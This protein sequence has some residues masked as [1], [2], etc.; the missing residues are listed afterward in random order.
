MDYLGKVGDACHYIDAVLTKLKSAKSRLLALAVPAW[1]LK[2][3]LAS[4]IANLPPSAQ[5]CAPPNPDA[6]FGLARSFIYSPE[7]ACAFDI[8][9]EKALQAI[10]DPAVDAEMDAPTSTPVAFGDATPMAHTA[11]SDDEDLPPEKLDFEGASGVIDH[12]EASD[13]AGIESSAG[14]GK[15]LFGKQPRDTVRPPRSRSRS[16]GPDA[17]DIASSGSSMSADSRKLLTK[18]QKKKLRANASKVRKTD[19]SDTAQ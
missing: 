18:N 5:A 3:Q 11:A 10:H 7:D 1:S 9:V 6:V 14:N 12:P 4:N 15:R 16:V 19:D 2:K 8:I 17:P 13:I